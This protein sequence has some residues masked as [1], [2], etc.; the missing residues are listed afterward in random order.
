MKKILISLETYDDYGHLLTKKEDQ[1]YVM[2][3]E[4]DIDTCDWWSGEEGVYAYDEEKDEMELLSE[5]YTHDSDGCRYFIKEDGWRAGDGWLT[6]DEFEKA[7]RVRIKYWEGTTDEYEEVYVEITD[8]V[9]HDNYRHVEV[10]HG[11]RSTDIVLSDP[12][13]FANPT[14]IEV[15]VEQVD[16]TPQDYPS[17]EGEAIYEGTDDEGRRIRITETYPFFADDSYPVCSI[18]FIDEQ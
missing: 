17:Q 5:T 3:D 13:G 2:V 16:Y 12:N 8:C 7:N 14:E 15:D 6:K 1:N 10:A 18:S 9:S 11:I 4:E